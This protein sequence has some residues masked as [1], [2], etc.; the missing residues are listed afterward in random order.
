MKK[1]DYNPERSFI[2]VGNKISIK[3]AALINAAGKYSKVFLSIVV[4]AVLARLLSAEDYGIVAIIT[5]FSTLFTT[6]SDMGFG[7]A[8]IQNKELTDNDIDSIFSFT[9]YI[10]IALMLAFAILSFPISLFYNNQVYVP[11]G[12]MLSVALLFDA[13][14][15]VPNGILNRD[16]KFVSIAVRTVVVYVGAAVITIILALMG[17]RYYALSIQAILTAFFTFIWNYT[18]TKPKFKLHISRPSIMKVLNYSGYQFAFNVV[19][20]FSRNL[21]NLLTGKFMGSAELGFYNRAYTLMLYP[22]NNLT[23][24]VS[25]VLHPLLADYQKQKNI[26]YSKYMKVV[27]LLVCIGLYFAPVCFLGSSEI[28]DILYGNN[29]NETVICFQILAIAIIPQMINASAGSIFQA[30]GNTKLLFVNSCINT[31]ITVIAILCGVFLGKSIAILSACVAGAYL[32]HFMTAF[33]MLI[34][35]GFKYHLR[36]FVKGLIPEIIMGVIMISAIFLY[37]FQIEG[38]F[39]SIIVKCVYLGI[40]YLIALI[41][42]KEYVIFKSLMKR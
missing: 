41:F 18:T 15:M 42:T 40:I 30:I 17:L 32:C 26:I 39:L 14:N 1:G 3:K 13:L 27:R 23:G 28:I 34:K 25:P 31:G 29:W 6:F 36:S 12:Q 37:P 21:D 38:V 5:V 22:V 35:L 10:S 2:K 4:N 33:Y 20:Y 19:N 8:I 16:K 24:V 11:L 9:V 7:P